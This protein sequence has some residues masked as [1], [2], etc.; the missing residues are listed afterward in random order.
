MVVGGFRPPADP[1]TT[2]FGRFRVALPHEIL[3][4]AAREINGRLKSQ[5]Y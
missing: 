1:F 5:C 4:Q 2:W 3:V